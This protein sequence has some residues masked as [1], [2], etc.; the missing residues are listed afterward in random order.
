M[1]LV[2]RHRRA[3]RVDIGGRRPRVR[4]FGFVD[5]DRRGARAHLGGERHRIRLQRQIAGRTGADDIELVVIARSRAGNEQFPIAAAAHPHR[6]P[7]RIPEIEIADH[8]DLPRIGR[9]H[10]ERHAA[11]RRRASSDARRACH[12]A[13]DRCLRRADRDR[14]R[15]AP[16]GSGRGLRGRRHCRRN[17]RAT[18]SAWRRSAERRRTG[19]HREC[20]P[21]A[22]LW[23][24][25]SI[26]STCEAS[27][28]NARTTLRSPSLCRPR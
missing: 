12:K 1:N 17:A 13:A 22:P 4:Q 28:R 8:A 26:A 15:S 6:M 24:C 16:A 2:D 18:D 3:E 25:S 20:A 27:G 7:P 5:H 23:P 10:H 14:S 19:R 11:R 21:A 9:Q